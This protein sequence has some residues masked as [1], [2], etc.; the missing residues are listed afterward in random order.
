MNKDNNN[1]NNVDSSGVYFSFLVSEQ[2]AKKLNN[3]GTHQLGLDMTNSGNEYESRK[4]ATLFASRERN[5][6][7]DYDTIVNNKKNDTITVKPIGWKLIKSHNTGKTCLALLIYS[8]ELI[9]AHEEIKNQTGLNHAFSTFITHISLH[10]DFEMTPE[11][12][13]DMPLPQFDIKLDRL[14]TKEY[15]NTDNYK[16]S[17]NKSTINNK[18]ELVSNIKNIRDKFLNNDI[19]NSIKLKAV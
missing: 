2:D 16:S 11:R 8:E 18:D 1:K 3:F 12:L 6:D 15:K 17:I 5:L 9:N 4:H 19:T 7:I 13:K 14:F 10:Y